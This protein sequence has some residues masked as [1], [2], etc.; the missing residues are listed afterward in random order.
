ML[1][2][3]YCENNYYILM[4]AATLQ[5]AEISKNLVK[6]KYRSESNFIWIIKIITWDIQIGC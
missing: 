4:E 1:H 6:Y 3:C 5:T 2:L